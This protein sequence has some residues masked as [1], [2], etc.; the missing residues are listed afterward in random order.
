MVDH[1]KSTKRKKFH[2]KDKYYK[3]AKEQG[4]RS[5][6]AFKLSQINRHYPLM[7][8]KT[9]VV[10]DLCAAPGG[11][12]QVAQRTCGPQTSIIAVD[13]LPIRSLGKRNITTIV[14]D[15]T[16]D[17]CKADINRA[18]AETTSA[19]NA[20]K[21]K[22]GRNKKEG[23]VDVVLHDG[24]PNIGAS[25][26]K[27]AYMQTELAVHALR[28]ATQHLR[29]MGSFVTKIYRSK[30]SASFQWVVKQLFREVTTFKPKASRQQSAEIFYV[31]QGYYK[32]DKIDPRLLDPKHIF[33]FV[34]GDT[35]GGGKETSGGV[36]GDKKYNVFHKSWDQ[37]KRHRGGYD[38]EHLDATMRHIE[39]VS[40]FVF[41]TKSQIDA[42]QMLST[43]TGF[44]FRSENNKSSSRASVC[45]KSAFLLNH[46]FTT[47]EIKEC[48]VDLKLL[49]KG[50]FKG[51]VLWREKMLT[52]WREQQKSEA[53]GSDD[54]DDGDSDDDSNASSD[55]GESAGE[56]DEN[57]I[58]KEIQKARE[59]KL[60][61]R[62]KVKKKERKLMAKKRRQAAF[63]MDLNAI[64]VQ[65]HDQ[66]FSLSTL[67]SSK[68][69]EDVAEV[70]LDKVTK[71]EAFGRDSDDDSDDSDDELL[72]GANYLQKRGIPERDQDTGYSFRMESELD[73]AYERFLVNT[74][75]GENK[76]GTKAAKRSKKQM[77]EK[78]AQQ[79][80]E[81]QEM[82][83]AGKKGINADTK[84]YAKLLQGARDSDD[85][86][87][88][89]SDDQEGNY[90][91]DDGFDEEP[92]T[93][94]EHQ[95]KKKQAAATT[96]SSSGAA[97]GKKS[98]PLI[99]EFPDD[100]TPMKTARW[101]SNPLFAEIGQAVNAA[102]SKSSS[103][104]AIEDDP[105][106]GDDDDDIDTDHKNDA[107]DEDEE[108]RPSKKTR[109]NANGSK[110]K[111]KKDENKKI[112][113]D[114]VWDMMPKTDKQKR[115]EKRIKAKER[116]ER[117]QARRAKK[118]GEE[119]DDFDLVPRAAADDDEDE[120]N[121]DELMQMEGMSE[122]KKQKIKDA[123]KLIKAGLGA[124]ASSKKGEK[125][126]FEV[127]E[128]DRPLPSKDDRK[129]DSANE[130]YDSDDHAETLALGTM[131]LRHSKAKSMVDASYNRFAWND[132]GDLPDWFVDDENRHYRPQ[133]PI[134]PAL[135]A[136]MKE[137]MLAL[138]TKPIA[139]VAEARARKNRK[140]KLK[141][142]NA[143][144]KAQSVANSSEM[145]EAMKLKSISKALR[146]DDNKSRK[147]YVVSKKGQGS[148]GVKGGVMVDKRM[149]NDKRG[150]DRATKK[151]KSGKKGGLTGSKRR[152]NHK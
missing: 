3:L 118:M 29:H 144:K 99:H 125:Q 102:A 55:D 143:K 79:S 112:T 49:N 103:K 59:R 4:L 71:E 113:A 93:P 119:A 24:A 138:S 114:D 137:K 150:M 145:S 140:A 48:V 72:G 97:A 18:I 5:R 73:M 80:H 7:H 22:D 131:M 123:R 70:N 34:E 124:G 62:K 23:T 17:K 12:T 104:A 11:W 89:G 82:V 33:E 52:V 126:G 32:P 146:S 40:D 127:V 65:E 57:A 54:S 149:K 141:L 105:L 63:G 134:P 35:Q 53:G 75:N 116:D 94:A 50:D 58:Q 69:L 108:K 41:G 109:R 92:M 9:N 81:D 10:L 95:A 78:M 121:D 122:E 56:D 31:C 136:K 47:N 74:K 36:G 129:Y 152:R 67:Q 84:A 45:P 16:T 44:T 117:R 15:I 115:H 83:L 107:D 30:D 64:E 39:P 151:R 14:G 42:I 1:G 110:S 26:D 43:C 51:L 106:A 19:S 139:K 88:D 135:L 86:D 100:P 38:T 6:A 2:D 91:S 68:D 8:S 20:A 25:Y 85:E 120:F 21:N 128:A 77:R 130:E 27:D 87:S 148:R 111:N 76:I 133:L 66:F 46:P 142:A 98:N 90:Q 101:F 37:A 132:P 96:A 60:R 147:E 13:I 61:E 28:C